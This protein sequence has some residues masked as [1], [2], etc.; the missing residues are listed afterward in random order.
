VDGSYNGGCPTSGTATAQGTTNFTG[1]I[2]DQAGNLSV[3]VTRSLKL[4]NV[5]PVVAWNSGGD[6]CSLPGNAGWCRATQ[7]AAFTASDAT[8]GLA[9]VAQ[10]AFTQA[11]GTNGTAVLIPSGAVMDQAGNV[12][13]GVNAGPYKIDSV[14]PVITLTNPANGANYLLNASVAANYSCSDA[15]SGVAICT[16]PV[17][18][19]ANI[20]T[21]PIASHSFTVNAT[22][23]AGNSA[24]PVTNNYSIM[25]ATGGMCAGSVGHAIRQPINLDGS[26]V[27]K[28]G[29][30]VPTKFAVCDANGVSIG[31][32]GVVTNYYLVGVGSNQGL[33]VDEDVYSTTPDTAFRWD[34][35]GL[36]WIFNQSTKNNVSLNHTGAIYYFAINLNDGSSISFQYGLK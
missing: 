30:T 7:T 12:S 3:T 17:A 24:T 19:G 32:P 16:G 9:N 18:N 8:S 26:S 35:T 23:A 36:Q 2:R 15:T 11:T 13:P 21:N 4:D 28:L 6:S 27:F 25:Y 10:A 20:S 31:T 5:A 14:A 34:P 1:Q 22:D 33:T 29:S